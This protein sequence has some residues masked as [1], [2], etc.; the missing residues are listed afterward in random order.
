MQI[1]ETLDFP[2]R[3]AQP[4]S[5]YTV[6]PDD[7]GVGGNVDLLQSC[8]THCAQEHQ[9]LEVPSAKISLKRGNAAVG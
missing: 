9:K 4:V 1:S 5:G 3:A 6:M 7:F 2:V 8:S